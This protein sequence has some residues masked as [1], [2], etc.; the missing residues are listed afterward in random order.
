M[1]QQNAE[2]AAHVVYDDD[3]KPLGVWT[4]DSGVRRFHRF[5]RFI[6]VGRPAAEPWRA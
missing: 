6:G 2:S 5:L 4:L 3:D 1:T